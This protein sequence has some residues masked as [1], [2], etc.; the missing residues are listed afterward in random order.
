MTS[1]EELL[2][3]VT[4]TKKELENLKEQY[5]ILLDDLTAAYEAGEVDPSFSHNDWSLSYSE[6]KPTWVYPEA[7]KDIE[8]QLKAAKRLAE[9][10]G[11]AQSSIGAP[12]WT[13]RKPQ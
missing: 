2:D 12:F 6:G 10:D 4:Q 9:A 11:T 8:K 13:L 3:K 5:E 1:I 7:V